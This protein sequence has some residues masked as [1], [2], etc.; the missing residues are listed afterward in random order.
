MFG[1]MVVSNAW[2]MNSLEAGDIYLKKLL[3][4]TSDNASFRGVNLK[5]GDV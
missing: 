3:A 4:Q 2:K 1:G 5:K